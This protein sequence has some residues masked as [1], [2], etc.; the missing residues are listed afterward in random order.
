M[1]G[2]RQG[3]LV[4]KRELRE[5]GRSRAFLASVALM[6]VTVAATLIIP[7]LFKPG[8]G[9]KD[10]GLTG[11]APTALAVTISQ[12]AHA[13]GITARV[14]HYGSLAAGERAV[15]QGRLDVLVGSGWSGKAGP[16][17]SSRPP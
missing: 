15:R 13:A 10:V 8:G 16:T 5:R 4:T 2:M 1:N 14:H 12:Q 7:A 17:S 6:V 11:R 9:T 3:W